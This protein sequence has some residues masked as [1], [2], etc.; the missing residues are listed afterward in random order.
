[1]DDFAT[2]SYALA[3]IAFGAFALVLLTRWRQRVHG[4]ALLAATIVTSIWAAGLAIQS[5]RAVLPLT[6]IFLLEI[7]RDA[8]WLV[9]LVRALVTVATRGTP[10]I[11]PKVVYGSIALVLLA[12]LGFGV[13]HDLGYAVDSAGAVL[14]PGA[15]LLSVIGLVLVE[16]VYRNTRADHEW[17]VKFL[18]IGIGALIVYDFCMY[19]TAL[20]LRA[21][22][23]AMWDARGA[24]NALCVLLLALGV[25]RTTRWAPQV[26]MSR[27]PAFYT[28][29]FIAAGLYLLAMAIAGYYVR[30][31]GGTWGGAGQLLFL[32]GAG[33]LLVVVLFSGQARARLKVFLAKHFSPYRYDYRSEWLHLTHT[34]AEIGRPDAGGARRTRAR[35]GREQRR[36]RNLD[37]KRGG[38]VRAFGR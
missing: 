19:S 28:L 35:S 8:L 21:I 31:V 15:M 2:V 38:R 16:Q 18:W 26:F 5:A 34:L 17:S 13:L 14:I 33:L 1:M 4:S 27:R 9:F 24:A 22:P 30:I 25:A 3:S 29:S 11:L 32:F 10:E 20:L 23:A 12:G 36:R 37:C 6:G 7:A